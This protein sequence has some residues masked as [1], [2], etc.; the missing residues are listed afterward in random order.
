VFLQTSRRLH[1]P[2]QT[3]PAFSDTGVQA[4][5]TYTYRIRAFNSA[6][7]PAYSSSSEVTTPAAPPTPP[8][9]PSNLTPSVISYNE[10]DLNWSDNATNEDGFRIERCKGTLSNCAASNFVQIAQ[11][12]PK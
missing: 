6:G 5:T 1:S 3:R 12:G 2:L 9:A 8:A 10:I 11:V 7:H 4:Q